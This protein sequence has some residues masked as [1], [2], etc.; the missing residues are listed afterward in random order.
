[1]SIKKKTILNCLQKSQVR[2]LQGFN[3]VQCVKVLYFAH[4]IAKALEKSRVFAGGSKL[5]TRNGSSCRN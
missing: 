4:K 1:M 5:T 3:G 2:V